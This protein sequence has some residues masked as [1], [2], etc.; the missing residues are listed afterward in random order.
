MYF[1]FFFGW[2]GCWFLRAV[3]ASLRR[4]SRDHC[5]GG[6]DFPMAAAGRERGRVCEGQPGP[7]LRPPPGP[8]LL[9]SAPLRAAA[10]LFPCPPSG[11]EAPASPLRQPR[12]GL[13]C[14]ST[15]RM[16]GDDRRDTPLPR[17]EERDEKAKKQEKK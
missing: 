4:Q 17:G 10:P 1:F 3:E 6:G 5:R 9:L 12:A 13:G 11:E 2:G 16:L 7:A 15:G 14:T 8:L